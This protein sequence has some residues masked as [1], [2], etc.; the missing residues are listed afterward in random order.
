MRNRLSQLHRVIL[1]E[2]LNDKLLEEMP[3]RDV[4]RMRSKHWGQARENRTQ[5]ERALNTLALEEM[6]PQQFERVCKQAVEEYLQATRD[7]QHE[8]NTLK[9]KIMCS[10]GSLALGAAGGTSEWIGKL[11]GLPTWTAI[12]VVGAFASTV[13]KEQ[14]PELMGVLKQRS[15]TSTLPGYALVRPYKSFLKDR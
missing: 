11:T 9:V 5:L 1:A 8:A 7:W 6:S 12:A 10:V 15:E 13:A 14:I 2:Y 3:I 4:V